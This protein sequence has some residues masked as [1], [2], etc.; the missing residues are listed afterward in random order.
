MEEKNMENIEII[1]VKSTKIFKLETRK[2]IINDALLLW[3]K[4]KENRSE[5]LYEKKTMFY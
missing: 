1:Q 2:K 4:L 5:N 3:N